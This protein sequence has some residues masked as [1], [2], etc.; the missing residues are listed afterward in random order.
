MKVR[1][2]IISY[3]FERGN[4]Y[5]MKGIRDALS[6]EY[7]VFILAYP[8]PLYG[9]RH[10]EWKGEWQVPNLTVYD[11]FRVDPSFLEEWIKE[12]GISIIF[13]G[14]IHQFRLM[15]AAKRIG[16]RVVGYIEWESF[17]PAFLPLY[18]AFDRIISPIQTGYEVLKSFG[19]ENIE[20]VRWGI[21]LRLFRPKDKENEKIRFFHPAGWMGLHGRRGTRFVIDGF[22]RLHNKR[23][24][25][26]LI[27]TQLSS[28]DRRV[29]NITL[30]SGTVPRDELIRMYQ[31]SDVA[32][33][34]SKWEGLGLTFLEA[35]GCGCA[36]ITVDAP[37]M[38]EHVVDGYN[39]FCCRVKEIVGY[40]GIFVDGAHVDV[41]DMAKKM[42]LLLDRDLVYSMKL[43]SR[44]RAERLYDWEENSMK[45]IDLVRNLV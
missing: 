4:P 1:I 33:L 19:L 17:N 13:L 30:L 18:K 31:A 35:M 42:E 22:K 15:E 11:K 7:E 20:F 44:K 38:N 29:E 26:L 34:P 3:W 12:N 6:K 39:G 28:K 36:V 5:V 8:S 43:K 24:A 41:D 27:H 32:V 2:G 25:E 21:D 14:D 9:G 37:P 16:V 45:I 23:D 40:P 10:I